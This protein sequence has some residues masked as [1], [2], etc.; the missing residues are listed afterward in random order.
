MGRSF[1]VS[2]R[3]WF[4]LGGRGP[5]APGRSFFVSQ[6]ALL[7]A[8]A[9]SGCARNAIFELELD[10]PAQPAGPALYAVVQARPVG[11]ADWD[12]LDA[13][14]GVPLCARASEGP[15]DD[16]VLDPACAAVLSVVADESELDVPLE[17]RV[18]Y[19]EDPSCATDPAAPEHLIDVERPFYRGRYT[20]ARVCL[21]DVAP[22]RET[23]E[24]CEV[25]CREGTVSSYCRL[26]GTH[27]CEPPN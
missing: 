17:V 8:L 18:R 23:L 22:G 13:L 7:A 6:C 1:L 14:P 24:R 3:A 11:G 10:L 4:P 2:E 26:D 12:T 25:R 20:Q 27:F 5:G 15:C 21:D 16:R 9:L 19:C